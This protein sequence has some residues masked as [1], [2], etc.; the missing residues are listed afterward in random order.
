MSRDH[1][2]SASEQ[3]IAQRLIEAVDRFNVETTGIDDARDLLITEAGD[4]RLRA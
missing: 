2:P 4:D 1:E 3:A